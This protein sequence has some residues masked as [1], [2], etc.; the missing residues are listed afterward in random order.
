MP[1]ERRERLL[2]RFREAASVAFL[3]A[4]ALAAHPQ[5]TERRSAL[6]DFFLLEK[7]AYELVYEAGNRPTWLDVP[8]AGL[9][10]LAE[11]VLDAK[12]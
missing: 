7:A 2:A 11:R 5:D 8:L 4:Y 3:D 9:A 10:A 1:D 6:V 12:R